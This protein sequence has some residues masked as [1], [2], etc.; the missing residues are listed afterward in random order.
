MKA[1]ETGSNDTI[2]AVATA[3]APGEGSV[4]IV[5]ISGPQAEPIGRRLFVPPGDQTW[6]SHRV[7]YGHVVDPA[8]GERVDEAL[9]LLMRAP[10][11]FTRETVVELHCHGGLVAVQRVLELVLAAGA[12][13]AQPGEFSQRAFLNGRLDLTRAEAIGEMI[14]A[15]SRRAA[16]LAMA[17]IDGGLQ[18]RLTALRG[19]LLDQL[20]E[21]EARV[22]F[23]E[24]LPPLDGA[25][26]AAELATVRGEL[27]RLVAE[28]RQGELLRQGLRVAIVGRPNV[29]KSSLLNLLS[30]RERAIVTDL[31]GTTRDLLESELVLEGVPLTLLDTAGIRDT[32]DRVEQLGIERSRAALAAADAVLLLFDLSA[33]WTAQDQALRDLVPPGAVLLV[34]GNKAD[35][36]GLPVG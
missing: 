32:G 22:D 26:V 7:L 28:A 2:A 5:R 17:G 25:A 10:R 13:R 30:R 12:R 16:Q 33:G 18:R 3:V 29:G 36:G 24:D 1:S 6:E 27:E 11:S 21:L 8:S 15:R 14:T 23:E 19:R 4:A 35:A 34:A 20:A 31:P 9:L